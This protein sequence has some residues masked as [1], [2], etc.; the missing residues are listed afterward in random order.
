MDSY[1]KI[2]NLFSIKNKVFSVLV[3]L[4][5]HLTFLKKQIDY[6]AI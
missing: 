2:D 4:L 6:N 3:N 1:L 5:F